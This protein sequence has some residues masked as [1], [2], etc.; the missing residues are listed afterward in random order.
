ML[1]IYAAYISG[2]KY[3]YVTEFGEV[4]WDKYARIPESEN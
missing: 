1:L 3:N 4:C 2:I